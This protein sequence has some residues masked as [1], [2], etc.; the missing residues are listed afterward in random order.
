MSTGQ[1]E[2][3][4]LAEQHATIQPTPAK[5]CTT[6]W[7]VV[8]TKTAFLHKTSIQRFREKVVSCSLCAVLL[9]RRQVLL[10]A[11][12]EHDDRIDE[13]TIDGNQLGI[14]VS[15]VIAETGGI[16][17]RLI[18]MSLR[19]S[20]GHIYHSFT[21]IVCYATGSNDLRDSVVDRVA[22]MFVQTLAPACQY[23]TLSQQQPTRS[24]NACKSG[25]THV[26]WAMRNVH[27]EGNVC[28]H[29]CFR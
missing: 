26:V 18:N 27:R 15:D 21:V 13:D 22:N 6:C 29:D 10:K 28:Q 1:S 7:E 5:L 17:H 23:G 4:I 20:I 9:A 14:N 19:T 8:T 25:L 3:A 12:R 2:P 11:A 16:S 24:I